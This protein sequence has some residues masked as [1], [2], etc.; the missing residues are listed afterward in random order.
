MSEPGKASPTGEQ[1]SFGNKLG[2]ISSTSETFQVI[3]CLG[4][5]GAAIGGSFFYYA[6]VPLF[7]VVIVGALLATVACLVGKHVKGFR[8][9][10]AVYEDGLEIDIKNKNYRFPY[11]DVDQY[12]IQHMHHYSRVGSSDIYVG[13]RATFE[14]LIAG[15]YS[16]I[17]CD[18]EYHRD[19]ASGKTVEMV[20][21]RLCDAVELKLSQQLDSEGTIPLSP[22]VSLTMDGLTVVEPL[23]AEQRIP[24]EVIGSWK[25]TEGQI[26]LTKKDEGLP[27]LSLPTSGKNF[28]PAFSLLAKMHHQFTKV[29]DVDPAGQ[30][31]AAAV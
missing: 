29:Q 30:Q 20:T 18:I 1:H 12:S 8:T 7:G 31:P 28:V 5:L 2:E 23:G 22:G 4:F 19:K 21:D 6:D 16:V 13:T 3:A 14:F 27:F 9:R 10:L 11:A 24:L 17:S 26:H 25:S 15:K